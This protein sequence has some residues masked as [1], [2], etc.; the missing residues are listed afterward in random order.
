[1]PPMGYLKYIKPYLSVSNIHHPTPPLPLGKGIF[2][3]ITI[4]KKE[5]WKVH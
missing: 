5:L 2:P 1:M 4:N 3:P